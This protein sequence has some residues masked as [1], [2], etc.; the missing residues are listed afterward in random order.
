MPSSK[1]F[2]IIIIGFTRTFL[3]NPKALV[4]IKMKHLECNAVRA[5]STTIS[6]TEIWKVKICTEPTTSSQWS[7]VFSIF[8]S[9]HLW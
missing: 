9:P 3:V 6:G 2:V 1:H 7:C 5:T 8:T 4:Y